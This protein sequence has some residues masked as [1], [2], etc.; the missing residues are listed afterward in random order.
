MVV[1]ASFYLE[2]EMTEETRSSVKQHAVNGGKLIA[3][4]GALTAAILG[5][6]RVLDKLDVVVQIN[7]MKLNALTAEVAYLR[8]RIDAQDHGVGATTPDA[9]PAPTPDELTTVVTTESDSAAKEES[10]EVKTL[11]LTYRKMP[12]SMEGLQRMQ[13]HMFAPAGE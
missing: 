3:A 1:G 13:E 6:N 10:V 12:L 7:A 4:I 11:G 9:V 2:I 5:Y 8:G